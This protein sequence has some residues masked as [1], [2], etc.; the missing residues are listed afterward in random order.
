MVGTVLLLFGVKND[1]EAIDLVNDV[2]CGLTSSVRIRNLARSFK[3]GPDVI[4]GTVHI[5][6]LTV[7]VQP[8]LIYG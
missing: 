1:E 3:F 2:C 6:S 7:H 8:V 5:N 4:G